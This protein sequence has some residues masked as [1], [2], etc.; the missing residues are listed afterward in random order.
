MHATS[1]VLVGGY[2]SEVLLALLEQELLEA[3]ADHLL[4]LWRYNR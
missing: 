3:S 4:S 1:L 2:R